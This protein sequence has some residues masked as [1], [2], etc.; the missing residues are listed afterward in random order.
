MGTETFWDQLQQ[1]ALPVVVEAWAP[2]CGPCRAMAP[3]L[4][5]LRQEYEGRVAVWK[6]N[7]D[8]RP[9]VV[10]ALRLHSVP[11]VVAFQ[12]GREVARQTG[13]QSPPALA[14]VFEAAL[15]HTP[16]V[17]GPSRLD[18]G[19]RIG[20]GLALLAL[21][22]YTPAAPLVM[23]AAGLSLFSAIHDRCP[24]WQAVRPRLTALLRPAAAAA[25]RTKQP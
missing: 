1:S 13:A 12:H 3:S 9:E 14:R 24:I 20:T 18:R 19:L 10:D 4:E 8:E 21:A 6:I 15:S 5:H 22:P 11:T 25:R 7:V 16:V 17:S 2:W 23:A